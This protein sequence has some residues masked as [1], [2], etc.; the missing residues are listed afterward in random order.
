MTVR[1]ISITAAH[2]GEAALVKVLIESG[3]NTQ[4]IKGYVSASQLSELS[5]GGRLEESFEIDKRTAEALFRSMK[6]YAAIRKGMDLLSYAKNTEKSLTEKLTRKGYPKDIAA[7][8]ASYLASHGMIEEE[9]DAELFA[10]TLAQRRLY[11]KNRIKTELYHKG[12]SKDVIRDTM[13]AL[14]VD[15]DEIC[16]KRIEKMGGLALFGDPKTKQKT[17]AA[18]MRYGFSFDNIKTAIDM[19]EDTIE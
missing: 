19:S 2:G 12:F 18:L 3:E 1:V 8:A 6:L 15:F 14:E 11:G 10:M 9:N 17:I 5:F 7:E 13:E 4:E 16:A